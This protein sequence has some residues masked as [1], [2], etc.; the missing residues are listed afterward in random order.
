MRLRPAD[1]AADAIE[2]VGAG[3]ADGTGL[4]SGCCKNCKVNEPIRPLRL[5]RQ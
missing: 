1:E 4:T 3:A 5:T 2:A